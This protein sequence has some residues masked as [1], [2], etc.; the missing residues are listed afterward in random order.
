[1][2]TFNFHQHLPH[3]ALTTEDTRSIHVLARQPI[4]LTS[5]HPF[6]EAGNTEFNMFLGCPRRAPEPATS[7]WQ[8][9]TIFTTLFGGSESLDN[10]WTN[11]ATKG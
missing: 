6:I 5:P 7:C 3:Y 1:M 9:L 4:D 2:T 8:I 11:L 10:F